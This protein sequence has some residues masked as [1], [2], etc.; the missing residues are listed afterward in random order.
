MGEQ[1]NLY[2]ASSHD[3]T[4]QKKSINPESLQS[5]EPNV[6]KSQQEQPKSGY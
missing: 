1:L 4:P 2:P 3:S 5:S 6:V